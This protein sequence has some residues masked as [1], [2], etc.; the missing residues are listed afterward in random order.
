MYNPNTYQVTLSNLKERITMGVEKLRSVIKYSLT[1]T[2]YIGGEVIAE[3]LDLS[4]IDDFGVTADFIC[5]FLDE[6]VEC[7]PSMET[8]MKFISASEVGA[9]ALGFIDVDEEIVDNHGKLL[10]GLDAVSYCFNHI[11]NANDILNA[12]SEHFH[13]SD[14]TIKDE[15]LG[16]TKDMSLKEFIKL[17]VVDV[18][19][20]TLCLGIPI[21]SLFDYDFYSTCDRY[22]EE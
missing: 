9:S 2:H 13:I 18:L 22:F 10:S 21:Q 11:E 5:K 19:F 4:Y 14:K 17:P 1:G 7:S 8:T 3:D 12:L 20:F 6:E 15:L 16:N